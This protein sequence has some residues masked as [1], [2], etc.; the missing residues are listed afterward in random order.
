MPDPVA[1]AVGPT[2]P[3]W[4]SPANLTLSVFPGV[5]SVLND[6]IVPY[7]INISA[8]RRKGNN[9]IN[10]LDANG[11]E[12]TIT[13]LVAY[14]TDSTNAVNV[15]DVLSISGSNYN[16]MDIKSPDIN[17]MSGTYLSSGV[18]SSEIPNSTAIAT[19]SYGF[20][21]SINMV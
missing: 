16:V 19:R 5:V 1:N 4:L 3:P 9:K 11:N 2:T 15:G 21:I 14:S 20:N 7:G 18:L 13:G 12:Q 10:Y 6:R 17:K 8:L